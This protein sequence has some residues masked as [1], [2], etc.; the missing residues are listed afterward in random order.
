M[1]DTL[2]WQR[3]LMLFSSS[4]WFHI[5]CTLELK[6]HLIQNDTESQMKNEHFQYLPIN[7]SIFCSIIY[8]LHDVTFDFLREL[9]F[10]L[11]RSHG[12]QLCD[13]L[14][15][16]MGLSKRDSKC[17]FKLLFLARSA[18][19][20]FLF[21]NFVRE[22]LFNFNFGQKK[23]RRRKIKCMCKCDIRNRSYHSRARRA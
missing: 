19:L 13:F 2:S 3:D 20:S 12:K 8:F 18:R 21:L 1:C 11:D 6:L 15:H 22:K 17:H 23:A 9:R 7:Q 14:A 10:L 4:L 16:E 5:I